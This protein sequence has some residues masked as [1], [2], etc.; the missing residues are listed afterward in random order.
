MNR[1]SYILIV[2]FILLAV[3]STFLYS[4]GEMDLSGFIL[5]T[6]SSVLGILGQKLS[7]DKR[8]RLNTSNSSE[9]L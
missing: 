4:I 3:I 8:K 7:V 5:S 6:S 1:F 2:M 9:E